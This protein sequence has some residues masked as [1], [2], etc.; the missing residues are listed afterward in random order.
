M[1]AEKLWFEC[2]DSE[3]DDAPTRI[4]YQRHR[5]HATGRRYIVAISIRLYRDRKAQIKAPLANKRRI[6][7]DLYGYL[8]KWLNWDHWRPQ[9]RPRSRRRY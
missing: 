7:K 9:H 3:L 6:D 4:R 8:A 5:N 1:A 2:L